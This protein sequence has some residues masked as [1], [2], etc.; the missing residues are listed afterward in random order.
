MAQQQGTWRYGLFDCF[1]P[2]NTC[3]LAYWCPCILFGRTKHAFEGDPNASAC[4]GSCCAW[5]ALAMLLNPA[6]SLLQMSQR[7]AMRQRYGIES[8]SLNDCLLSCCCG[9]CT[10]IQEDKELRSHE[11]EPMMQQQGYAAPNGGQGMVYQQPQPGVQ[12]QPQ[13]GVSEGQK[14]GVQ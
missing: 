2:M 8:N 7:G 1:S 12:Q 11:S 13:Y 3:C 9:C 14:V 5:T 6:Q 4:N 10:L